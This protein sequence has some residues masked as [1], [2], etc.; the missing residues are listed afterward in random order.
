M[1]TFAPSKTYIIRQIK[2]ETVAALAALTLD[3][4][5]PNVT[6]ESVETG[7]GYYNLIVFTDQRT[8]IESSTIKMFEEQ[9]QSVVE[10]LILTVY[11]AKR[12]G[13]MLVL[14]DR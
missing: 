6:F 8:F 4:N 5:Y 3:K 14:K 13:K 11:A 7:C 9:A 1:N 10:I 2:D 12:D